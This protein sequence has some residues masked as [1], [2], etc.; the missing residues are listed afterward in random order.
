MRAV[1]IWAAV[2]VAGGAAFA[3]ALDHLGYA[4]GYAAAQIE[5]AA[6]R[7]VLQVK[8]NDRDARLRAALDDV[9]AVRADRA[10]LVERLENEALADDG[11]DGPGL[12]LNGLRRLGERW[13][14]GAK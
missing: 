7:D 9:A 3:A 10:A 2:L 11:A 1:F 8:I 6:L 13:G 12:G 5:A 14:T 4:R